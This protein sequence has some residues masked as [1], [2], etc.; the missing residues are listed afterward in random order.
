MTLR[1]T[2]R[3]LLSAAVLL[4]FA[5]APRA[6]LPA[7]EVIPS[8]PSPQAL[9][10]SQGIGGLY[11][12]KRS[13]VA[14][15]G[16]EFGV[17]YTDA[18]YQSLIFRRFFAD[19]SPAAAPVTV[20]PLTAN[21]NYN[22]SL[23][24]D[25][26]GYAVAWNAYS[27]ASGSYQAYFARL[28]AA[29]GLRSPVTKVSFV[30]TTELQ[31]CYNPSLAWDGG[32]YAVVWEDCRPL[33]DAGY[34][35]YG[36][37]LDATGTVYT[38]DFPVVVASG[39]QY[40]PS[41]T[42]SRAAN[43]FV[44]AYQDYRSGTHFQISTAYF[45]TGGGAT[46]LGAAV[47]GASY[48][49]SPSLV[50]SGGGLG[51]A[52]SDGRDGNAEIYFCRL[53]PFGAKLG[54]EVRLTSDAN[55]SDQS[56]VLWTGSEYGVFWSDSR[57]AGSDLWF[58]RVSALGAAVGSNQE[59]TFGM[60]MLNPDA[61]FAKFGFLVTGGTS[62]YANSALPWGCAADTTPP[63]CPMNLVA[64]NITGTTATVAWVPSVEDA[65]D[66][67][68]YEV[69]RNSALLARTSDTLYT[70]SG[71]ALSGSYNYYVRPVN[72]AQLVN[73]SCTSSIYVK[74]N[75]TLLLM[76][77]KSSDGTDADLTWTDAQMNNYNVFRST[78]PR[79]MSQIGATPGQAYTDPD[80]LTNTNLYFYTVD[81]PGW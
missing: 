12:S 3:I 7:P 64:Y 62:N 63:S 51:M 37:L 41:V 66:L 9:A 8:C 61:A 44:V 30:G 46:D 21:P 18:M 45:N 54:T 27:T 76:V 35:I 53:S 14:W 47:S 13:A 29:G 20:S 56:R 59:V 34:D 16:K 17:V 71:L 6:G 67:A 42:F 2:R 68:Y 57:G 31:G 40:G 80:A 11:V 24:W 50:D 48:S 65:T 69:Y 39:H 75:A 74:T 32:R 38:H 73:G 15:S 70:D 1:T 22:A 78:D 81:E 33:C 10:P 23:L 52:W 26:T 28:D 72:A 49:I 5:L 58:Q 19:G 79:V 43:V 55:S 60:S 4:T 25:G 77:N 36:T